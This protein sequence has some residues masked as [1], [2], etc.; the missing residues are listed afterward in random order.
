VIFS[1][2]ASSRRREGRCRRDL[3]I[4][5][6]A[7]VRLGAMAELANGLGWLTPR[8]EASQPGHVKTS[9]GSIGAFSPVG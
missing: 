5:R 2:I 6:Q 8:P 4:E 9:A 1:A 3:V 7:R